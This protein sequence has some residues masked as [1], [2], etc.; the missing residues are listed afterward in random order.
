MRAIRDLVSCIVLSCVFSFA[1][2]AQET[3]AADSPMAAVQGEAISVPRLIRYTGTLT[4]P[5]GCS[6]P[7]T[8]VVD[9]AIYQ[10]QNDE[11][12]LWQETQSLDLD[13]QGHYSAL[14][15]ASQVDGLP[16]ELFSTGLARW[17]SVRING[18]TNQP[19]TLLVAV[20]Y[21]LKASDADTLGGM[22]ASAFAL[23]STY[24]RS[25]NPAT[26]SADTGL[27]PTPSTNSK[28]VKAPNASITELERPATSLSGPMRPLS[29]TPYS[30]R[31]L[32]R[33]AWGRPHQE[34]RSMFLVQASACEVRHRVRAASGCWVMRAA[35]VGS[36]PA[37]M[38]KPQAPRRTPLALAVLRRL[39]PGKRLACGGSVAVRRV[40]GSWAMAPNMVLWEQRRMTSPIPQACWVKQLPSPPLMPFT[41]CKALLQIPRRAALV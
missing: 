13:A 1:G 18:A 15:G 38:G 11:K 40:L 4:G 25:L 7:G 29:Q 17:L 5:S 16:P 32:G 10:D 26:A 27:I 33:L 35:R 14:L 19:R 36:R 31:R 23:S 28:A 24:A 20:P 9:F 30:S 21:A 34:P 41:V 8:V 2:V 3:G 37:F 12:P 6:L 22:P 39:P